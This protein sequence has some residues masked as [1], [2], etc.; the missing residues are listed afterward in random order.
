MRRQP[1][2]P[3]TDRR[4][5]GVMWAV[6]VVLVAACW[7][8]PADAATRPRYTPG[9]TECSVVS[10]GDHG[11][12]MAT[13]FPAAYAINYTRRRDL[14]Y[15]T[16]RS[17][18]WRWDGYN[19]NLWGRGDDFVGLAADNQVVQAWTRPSDG[20]TELRDSRIL[21]YFTSPG[22]YRVAQRITWRATRRVPGYTTH[23]WL[24]HYPG[25]G[26]GDDFCYIEA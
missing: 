12:G 10:F 21:F 16:T 26:G 14:Q 20:D 4:A 1:C 7:P 24:K 3:M 2:T 8:A 13:Y 25:Y 11:I 9:N 23:Q 15:V 22:F 17:D 5:R 19:W 18:L 6:M